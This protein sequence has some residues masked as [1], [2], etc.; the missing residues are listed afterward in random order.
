[1]AHE[2]SLRLFLVVDVYPPARIGG[3]TLYTVQLA[4][5]LVRFGVTVDVVCAG[6]WEEG[7]AHFN[8]ITQDVRN[9]VT[10]H[11]IH[12]NWRKAPA[13]FDCLYDNETLAPVFRDLLTQA[14]PDVVHVHSCLTLSAR[15]IQEAKALQIPVVLHLHQFWFMCALQNLVRKDGR[16]CPG[17]E[18]PWGC[19][20]CVLDGAKALRWSGRFLPGLMQEKLLSQAGRFPWITRQPGL[21]GMLGDIT[22]RQSYLRETL[23]SVDVAVAP[24][25]SLIDLFARHGFRTDHMV[26]SLQGFDTAWAADVQRHSSSPIRFGYIGHIQ[27]IKGVHTLVD[28]FGRLP[29]GT[30]AALFIYGDPTQQPDYAQAL[31]AQSVASVHW[32]GPFARS[33]LASVLSEL[34]VVVV[35][36]LSFEVNPTV[37]KEAFAAGVPVIVSDQPGVCETVEHEVC[38]LHFR[39]ADADDLACQ[40]ARIVEKP[41]LLHQLRQSIPVV[42]TITENAQEMMTIYA[43]LHSEI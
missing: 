29:E 9:G 36:S 4:E 42:K 21:V 16:V 26:Y 41:E 13:P 23:A 32:S 6:A 22:R 12:L 3:A 1:M 37:I 43:Q 5:Q 39:T 33:Q 28:A 38:G 2:S 19:Q 14:R 15:V 10:V 31:Q 11:R 18:S 34:D 8:G 30:P 7:P 40:I 17:P 24:A 25:H 20:A 27:Q 35:P